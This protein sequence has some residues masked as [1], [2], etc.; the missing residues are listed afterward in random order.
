L[1]RGASARRLAKS[2]KKAGVRVLTDRNGR[3]KYASAHDLRS[4][5]GDRWARKVMPIV[6]KEQMW[7]DSR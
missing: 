2:G 5:F 1:E 3:V 6:L 7:Q 4:S